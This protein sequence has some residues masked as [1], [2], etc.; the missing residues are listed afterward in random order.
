MNNM[1]NT[2]VFVLG[3]EVEICKQELFAVLN[4]FGIDFTVTSLYDNLLS[5]NT[6]ANSGQIRTMSSSLGGTTKVFQIESR[7]VIYNR[8]QDIIY[9][10]IKM[11]SSTKDF[12]ISA[13]G[14]IKLEEVNKLGF[15]VKKKLKMTGRNVRFVQLK[16]KE[17]I[18]SILSEKLCG[19]RS[20][21]FSFFG[22]E[23]FVN[24]G[25][26]VYV[27]DAKRW[28]TVDFGKPAGDKYSGMLPPK[29]ARIMINLAMGQKHNY[30][31]SIFK[32]NSNIKQNLEIGNWKLVNP[33]NK[34]SKDLKIEACDLKIHQGKT[35]VVDP[36]CGSGNIG[37]EAISSG[38][39]YFGSDIS[40]KAVGDTELNIDWLVK[41]ISI[42]NP[43]A[44][45]QL[46]I[47]SQSQNYNIKQLD[48]T[49][50]KFIENCKLV[51]E[52]YDDAIIV[53][54]PY[55]GEPKR[56]RQTINAAK[57]EYSK[58]R[59]LYL[60]FFKNLINLTNLKNLTVCLVFPLVE[61]VEDKK[62]CLYSEIVDE[63]KKLGYIELTK[64]L[65]Y[66]REYQVVK[67]KIVLL[68]LS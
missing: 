58:V 37:L 65:I 21:E 45:G 34:I 64:P 16:D 62:Y 68:K 32:E 54:E 1:S 4:Y 6:Q 57:G 63:I 19:P 3:R 67:R 15:S 18:S 31:D 52:N 41:N 22:Y 2:F 47:N 8:L 27:F 39:D 60:N 51:I 14:Q 44:G 36:F 28:S 49:S 20:V 29:L 7:A 61:T 10:A 66:G 55:L 50:P 35:L 33:Q 42:S 23:N 9:D 40:E 13:Y 26:L 24:V 59:E 11:D 17:E 12:G 5:I 43:L 38:L 56:F 53:S 46:P 48:A 25:R 30:L